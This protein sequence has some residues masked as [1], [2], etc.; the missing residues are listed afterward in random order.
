MKEYTVKVHDNGDK[1]WYLNGGP[2]HREDGPAY[3]GT[4]GLKKWCLHGKLHREDGPAAEFPTG[5]KKWYLHGEELTEEE[6]NERMVPTKEMT[7]AELEAVL[8]HKLKVI[9]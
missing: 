2:L 7:I 1:E 6:F 3:E 5:L 9:K 4:D 8:G